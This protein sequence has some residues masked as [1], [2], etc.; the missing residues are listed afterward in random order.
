MLSTFCFKRAE[1]Y[2]AK[3]LQAVP[4]TQLVNALCEVGGVRTNL[5]EMVVV[6][7]HLLP[8]NPSCNRS[9]T[10]V[11]NKDMGIDHSFDSNVLDAFH[12]VEL[13]IHIKIDRRSF[14]KK[15]MIIKFSESNTK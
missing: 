10:K 15:S 4:G 8:Y 7:T 1:H 5:Y 6:L 9:K 3:V 13:S 12:F 11:S 2:A 14:L